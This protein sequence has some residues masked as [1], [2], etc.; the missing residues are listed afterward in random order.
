M[1]W[2]KRRNKGEE[3][4]PGI[5][6]LGPYGPYRN[7]CW[8]LARGQEAAILEMPPCK[9]REAKP[10]ND[11][12]R[13]LTQLGLRAKYA[14]LSHAHLDHCRSFDDFR[15]VFPK[16]E[17]VTH[18]SLLESRFLGSRAERFDRVFHQ[19]RWTGFLGGEPLH[20]IWAPKH[21][22]SDQMVM[23]RGSMVTGDWYLGDLKDCNA[24]VAPSEKIRSIEAL[25][26]EV[27]S[28]N[29]YVHTLF[30]AHGDCRY[31]Q[32]DFKKMMRLSKIDHDREAV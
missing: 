11:A 28:L 32:V 21:S 2:F 26:R 15:A 17:F 4:A 8:I 27:E 3:V 24:L 25:E 16:T 20:V 12:K 1:N 13:L 6:M 23:F 18:S 31:Y 7:A 30:S 14:L 29:Y 10:W 9:R 22:H 19:R 5:Y